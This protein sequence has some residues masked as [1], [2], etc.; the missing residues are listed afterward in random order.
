MLELIRTNA[1]RNPN[2]KDRTTLSRMAAAF[3]AGMVITAVLAYVPVFTGISTN[4]S[5]QDSA[6]PTPSSAPEFS[7][8]GG[9]PDGDYPARPNMSAPV[10]T[11]YKEGIF[12]V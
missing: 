9:S 1:N 8:S 7:K 12:S 4:D 10:Y 6:V 11:P 2:G 5:T 3:S